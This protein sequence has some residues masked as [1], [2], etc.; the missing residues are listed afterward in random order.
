MTDPLLFNATSPFA[1]C[2]SM[3]DTTLSLASGPPVEST[4]TSHLQLWQDSVNARPNAIALISRHQKPT[5]FRWVGSQHNDIDYVQWTYSDLD[6]GA[7]RLATALNR[8]T[9]VER[10]PIATI[11][12]TQAEWALFCWAA[13]YLHSPLVPIN[14]KVVT[15]SREISHMLAM[16]RPAVVV[17]ADATLARQLEQSLSEEA[18]AAIPV[19]LLT[20]H[21]GDSNLSK[22]T[23]L[24]QVMS[25]DPTPPDTPD[26]VHPKDTCMTLFTSG[27]TSLPKPCNITSSM[28][29]NAGLGYMEARQI[30][31]GHKLVQHLPNFHSYG[32]AWSFAFWFAG[33]TVVLP[34][35]AFEA[36][37]SLETF[38]MFK[39]THMSLVPTTAQAILAHPYFATAD[40]STLL[41]HD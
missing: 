17:C 7:R 11:V 19:K 31:S 27:T 28:Y 41:R 16:T 8:L 29:V 9:H 14:P 3:A 20:S 10:R 39:T 26:V 12:N 36:Q 5:D 35:E 23:A 22:W 21:S 30:N 18:R 32:I 40:L 33:A 37:A 24:S 15:R 6:R 1:T 13:A 38:D 4:T 34:S 25:G 2:T